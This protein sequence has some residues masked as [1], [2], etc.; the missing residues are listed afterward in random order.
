MGVSVWPVVE[1]QEAQPCAHPTDTSR[2]N[3][4]HAASVSSRYTPLE[5]SC[6]RKSRTSEYDGKSFWCTPV[7]PAA[8][9]QLTKKFV[10]QQL[11]VGPLKKRWGWSMSIILVTC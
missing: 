3:G 11:G 5:D 4:E 10:E 6:N 1:R 7:Q 9:Q 2:E 8:I